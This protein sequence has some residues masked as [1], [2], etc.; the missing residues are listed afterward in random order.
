MNLH[1]QPEDC[2]LKAL[3]PTGRIRLCLG[4][5]LHAGTPTGSAAPAWHRSVPWHK[6]RGGTVT[7]A[8]VRG[9]AAPTRLA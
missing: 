9:K 2:D 8:L 1:A 5:H 4:G 3:L 6:G 7:G